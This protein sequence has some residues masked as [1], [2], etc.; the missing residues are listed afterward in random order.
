VIIMPKTT[1]MVSHINA[2]NLPICAKAF[3]DCPPIAARP[4]KTM[5]DNK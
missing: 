4:K 5:N 2:N 1:G 3:R